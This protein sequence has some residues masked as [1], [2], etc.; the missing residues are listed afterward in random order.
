ML[1]TP[2]MW[3]YTSC[4]RKSQACVCLCWLGTFCLLVCTVSLVASEAAQQIVHEMIG[5]A[6][7][8][9]IFL[10]IPRRGFIFP[11]D[12]AASFLLTAYGFSLREK[13]HILCLSFWLWPKLIV[14]SSFLLFCVFMC[15][16]RNSA[17][18]QAGLATK[19]ATVVVIFVRRITS[20]LS[21]IASK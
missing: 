16:N 7:I 12:S 20:A 6:K 2:T 8:Y 15:P 4:M 5:S 21:R 14:S 19:I 13:K 1:L 10:F 9:R 3:W 17:F 11:R 18:L